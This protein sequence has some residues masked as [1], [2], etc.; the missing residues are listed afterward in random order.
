MLNYNLDISKDSKWITATPNTTAST[1]PFY[2]TEVG[3][4]YAHSGYFTDRSDK[5]GYQIIYTLSGRGFVATGDHQMD[6]PEKH[7]VLIDCR[8]P[9]SFKTLSEE[10]WVESWVHLNG[11]GLE[12]YY[13]LINSPKPAPVKISDD[14]RFGGLFDELIGDGKSNDVKTLL[15]R[16]IL[17][18]SML[19]MMMNGRLS[20]DNQ[21]QEARISDIRNAVEFIQEHYREQITVESL[22]RQFN[23]SKY[24]F[25]RLFK[26][27]MGTSPYDYL[28]NYR[29]NRAKMLLNSTS[30][31]IAEI[32]SYVGFLDVC[33]FIK[34][35]KRQTGI[36]PTE[37][38]S[39]AI[40]FYQ[41]SGTGR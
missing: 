24:Y 17:L 31:T 18:H 10:P 29:I 21:K 9:Q 39:N 13:S 16:S 3:K 2:M 6:L 40:G 20:G 4:F 35:F 19:N 37:Y 41:K 15:R 22:T 27:H 36:K 38:R 28:I 30:M 23:I 8:M 26:Q 1:L 7:A 25:I 14:S 11:G 32:A 34:H 5:P 12:P 33:N